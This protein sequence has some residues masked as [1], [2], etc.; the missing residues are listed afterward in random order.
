MID[1]LNLMWGARFDFWN[2]AVLTL[3]LTVAGLLIGM[4]LGLVLAVSR[5][6]GP[7]WLRAIAI[8]YI[9]LFRGTPLLVQLFVLYYGLPG[10]KPALDAAGLPSRWVVLDRIPCAVL[11]LGLNSAAYQAEYLR[12][13]L[14]AIGH[15]QMMAARAIGMSR[16]RAVFS[17]ILPQAVRL[18]IPAWANEPIS[19]LKSSA[20]VY[21]IAVQELM[22]KAKIVQSRTYD[23]IG[24]YLAVAVIYL[25]MVFALDYLLKWLE[26]LARIPGF[27]LEAKR[28]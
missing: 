9:E 22:G 1:W 16:A 23:V 4:F 11:A 20:I 21:L 26:R 7:G 14:L 15:G 3:E 18:V 2:G 19:L 27:E 28:A 10:L 6:Y 13:S 25:I 8:G 24:T 12:G 17:I 5:S